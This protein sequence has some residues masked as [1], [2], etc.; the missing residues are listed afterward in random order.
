MMFYQNLKNKGEW[1]LFVTDVTDTEAGEYKCKVSSKLDGKQ[2]NTL[3]KESNKA[4]LKIL[5]MFA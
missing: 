4:I 2:K 3:N 1:N 5:R